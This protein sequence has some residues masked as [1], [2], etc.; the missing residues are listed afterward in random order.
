VSVENKS[1]LPLEGPGGRLP[2]RI[3][4]LRPNTV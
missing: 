1:I 4:S 3:C 2:T